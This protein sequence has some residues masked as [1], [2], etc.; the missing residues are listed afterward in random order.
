VLTAQAL[1]GLGELKDERAI[2]LAKE[3]AAYGKPARA[4]EAALACLGKLGEGKSDVVEFLTDYV[5]DPWLRARNSAIYALQE[6]KDDKAIP[7]LSRRIRKELDGRIIRSCREA[8]AAIREGKDRSDDVKKLRDDMEKLQ[9]EN[10]KLTD[11]LNKL[12][13]GLEK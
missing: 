1:D 11:R 12:E 7:A 6:L 9:E 4:R 3:W 8:I 13:V 10:R 5:D 2:P